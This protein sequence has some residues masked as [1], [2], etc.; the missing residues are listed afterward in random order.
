MPHLQGGNCGGAQ[1]CALRPL[2][3]WGVHRRLADAEDHVPRV[4][5]GPCT[6][7]PFGSCLCPPKHAALF[8]FFS[9]LARG[10]VLKLVVL[11]AGSYPPHTGM[12]SA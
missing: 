4:Q 9:P 3:L 2:L 8:F 11:S 10:G 7:W 5:V 1:L 6:C 12:R